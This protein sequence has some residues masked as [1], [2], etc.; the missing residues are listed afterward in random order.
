MEEI[1]KAKEDIDK[2]SFEY[3]IDML[4]REEYF[5]KKLEKDERRKED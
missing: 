1:L 4:P 2:R 3:R 5:E